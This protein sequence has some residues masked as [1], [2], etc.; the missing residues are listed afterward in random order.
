MKELGI[1]RVA[2]PCSAKW[3]RMQGT[4]RVRL[5]ASCGLNVYHL[6]R[7]TSDDA[8]EL[9]RQN[10]GQRL[11]VRFWRRFDGTLITEDCP[12]SLFAW[13]P[14]IATRVTVL[15]VLLFFTSSLITLLGN[16]IRELFGMTTMGA[17]AGDDTVAVRKPPPATPPRPPT[18]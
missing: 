16:N 7:M 1:V 9:I 10:E 17:L 8:R 2:R 13:R 3:S 15:G 12:R 6:S 4:D 11:C 18:R 14:S 5:C